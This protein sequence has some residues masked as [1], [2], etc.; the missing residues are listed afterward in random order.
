GRASPSSSLTA[1]VFPAPF[2]PRN[3]KTSPR[4]TVIERAS[5]AVVRRY[6]F[7]RSIVWTAGEDIPVWLSR[8]GPIVVL[9]WPA[10]FAS[11]TDLLSH[12]QDISFVEE[13]GDDV[14]LV[15]RVLPHDCRDGLR[16][17]GEHDRSGSVDGRRGGVHA[18]GNRYGEGRAHVVQQPELGAE[19]GGNA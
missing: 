6:T 11:S 2:G 9:A 5:S 15:L 1:V 10:R 19:V 16:W 7:R 4:F 14:D 3:P 18:R 8:G 17:I 12:R 13:P